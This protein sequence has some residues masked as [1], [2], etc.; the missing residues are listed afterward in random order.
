MCLRPP[1]AVCLGRRAEGMPSARLDAGIPRR[2]GE[3]WGEGFRL[4]LAAGEQTPPSTLEPGCGGCPLTLTL[5]LQGE[6]IRFR[7][8]LP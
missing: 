2:V 1:L 4:R 3:G 8:P 5:S 6:G 7:L